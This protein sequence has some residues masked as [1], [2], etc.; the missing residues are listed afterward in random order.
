MNRT[1]FAVASLILWGLASPTA[2]AQTNIPPSAATVDPAAMAILQKS[3]NKMFGLK[4][5]RAACWTT[6]TLPDDSQGKSQAPRYAMATLTAAKPRQ[7]RYD[8]W[9][10]TAP[11]LS[12]PYSRWARI[13]RLPFMTTV[14]DG[15]TFWRQVGTTYRKENRADFGNLQTGLEPW[16]GF[17]TKNSSPLGEILRSRKNGGLLGLRRDG[18]EIVSGVPC[19]VVRAQTRTEFN[20]DTLEYDSRLFIG[21]DG[22]VR[23]RTDAV[24]FRGAP[25]RV[26]DAVIRNIVI[27]APINAPGK[28]FAYAPPPGVKSERQVR[29]ERVAEPPLLASGT[30]A[31]DFSAADTDGNIVTLSGLRGKVVVVDFWAS[32]CGPCVL[33]MPH[34]QRVI[35]KLQDGGVPVVFLAVDN[36][37][38]RDVFAGWVKNHPEYDAL[39]FVHAD[40]KTSD[41]SNKLYRVSGIPTQYIVDASGIIRSSAVGFGGENDKM[42]KAIRAALAQKTD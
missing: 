19:D 33:S 3:Q 30:P 12:T 28:T 27:N 2:P 38:G 4:T 24:K 36:S 9:I 25:Y 11:D 21:R 40:R 1:I 16:G 31:P 20:G 42:E 39:R 32:W 41:I 18:T 6:T 35:K 8:S 15:G 14:S 22:I 34:N 5:F 26:S 10:M 29:A 23:R 17:H 13:G 7:V 37:E